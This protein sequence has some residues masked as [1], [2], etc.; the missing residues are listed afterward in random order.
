[1]AGVFWRA[2]SSDSP[3]PHPGLQTGEENVTPLMGGVRDCSHN[4]LREY[5]RL[6]L[7][8]PGLV[9]GWLLPSFPATHLP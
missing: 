8:T 1:M 3:L 7:P 5:Q 9:V 2:S 4:P 6:V